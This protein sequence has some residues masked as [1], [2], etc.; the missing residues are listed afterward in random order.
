MAG[1]QPMTAAE[2]ASFAHALVT[3]LSR[4]RSSTMPCWLDCA[5]DG[6]VVASWDAAGPLGPDGAMRAI[7]AGLAVA[8]GA[9][10]VVTV[11]GR[12]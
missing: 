9:G 7:A 10:V 4:P 11:G 12:A 8:E 6:A 2:R 1:R 3:V 5:E